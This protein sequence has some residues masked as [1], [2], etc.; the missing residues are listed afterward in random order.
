VRFA[1]AQ[2]HQRGL[3]GT[4]VAD[5]GPCIGNFKFEAKEL[6]LGLGERKIKKEPRSIRVALRKGKY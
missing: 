6:G 4:A 2:S 5:R 1:E 3:V